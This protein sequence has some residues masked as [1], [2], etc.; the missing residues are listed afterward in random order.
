MMS[1]TWI[2]VTVFWL[3]LGGTTGPMAAQQPQG[4]DRPLPNFDIRDRELPAPSSAADRQVTDRGQRR[5]RGNPHTG[6]LRIVDV[7]DLAIARELPPEGIRIA[8][9]RVAARL[10][11]DGPDL[12]SLTPLRDFTSA[13]N[14]VR[15]VVFGQTVDGIRVLDAEIQV[16]LDGAG[17]AVRITS[18]AARGRNRRNASVISA[19]QAAVAAA[20]NVRP[21]VVFSPVPVGPQSQTARFARGPFKSDVVVTPAWFPMSDALRLAWLVDIELDGDPQRY[22]IVVDAASGEVLLRRNK[23]LYASGQGRVLQSAAM[24]LLDARRPEQHPAGVADCPPATNYELRDLA[25]PFRDPATVL[26]ST[27][28]LSGNNTHVYRKTAASEAEPGVFDGTQWTFDF[29]L[30]SSGGAETSLF[31]ALNF[32]HDFF[33]DL[34][35]D[36]AAGNFQVDNFGRGGLGGD[37]IV[38]LARAVGRNNATFQPAPDGASPTISMFLWDGVG[39][40]GR[41]LDGDGSIDLDGDQDLDIVLHEYHHGVSNRLNTAFSGNEADAIGE[42]GSDFFAYSVNGDTVLAEYSYPGGLRSVNSKTYGDWSCLL[43]ILCDPHSNGEIWANVLWDVRERFRGDNVRGST[44]AAINEVHQLYVD[45][46]ALSPPAPTMLDMRDAILL[47]DTLRNPSGSDSANFCRIWESFAARGMGLD[48]TDTADNGQNRVQAAFTVPN[49]CQP[50]PPPPSVSVTT[51]NATANEAGTVSG[52]FRITR[53]DVGSRALTVGFLLGG[54]A[55]NG[56]DYMSTP[57]TAVIPAGSLFADLVITPIDD[58]LVEPSES[59]SLTLRTSTAYTIASPSAASLSIVSDD[60]A[61]DLIVSLLTAPQIAG[62]GDAVTL[63]ETT[64]NQGTGS[65]APSVTSFYL[66]RDYL[67]DGADLPLGTRTIPGLGVGAADSGTTT[68]TLPTGLVSG[69]YAIFAKADNQSEISEILESNNTRVTSIRIGPDLVVS[70]MSAP[71][72]AGAGATIAITETTLNQGG[73]SA[74]TSATRFYLSAN[75]SLDANDTPLGSRAVPT[76]AASGSSSAT[77]TVSIPSGTPTGQYYLIAN[78][79]DGNAVA[80][81]VETNNVKYVI[82]RVGPDLV[83]S[84]IVAPAR[85]GSGGTIAITDTTA[86]A[87]SGNADA[88]T[89]TFYFSSNYALDASDIR[90]TPSRAVPALAPGVSST[91]STTVSVPDLQ[92]GLWYLIA[93]AD[94]GAQ[95]GETYETNNA[96]YVTILVG[97]DLT[98]ASIVAPSSATAGSTISVTDGVRNQGAGDAGPSVTRFYLSNNVLF[99]S[100]DVLL[101]GTRSVPVVAA[102][103]TNTGTASV[104]LPTGLSGVYFIIVVTDGTNTVAE[105]SET[106]N[107]AFRGITIK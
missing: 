51:L 36:E 17:R 47:A 2:A 41:D 97:P 7:T 91:T 78:A 3:T 34:G 30:E 14:N 60:I 98:V 28:R 25:S 88:S 9:T 40:W 24:T 70:T 13:S 87:G 80:E 27:G 42:G 55:T 53:N 90:L 4:S 23:I 72:T 73:G 21:S 68:V 101:P 106:N 45:A 102:G 67:L 107:S 57:L 59:V 16:H 75:F 19:A 71:A 103:A 5:S 37:P 65:A 86:N 35:F 76:L 93:N 38:G 50:P 92:P 33:Y 18:S 29:P 31:F 48:A 20:A 74:G 43:S 95:V 56:T 104:T 105:A 49:G 15:H 58:T 61:P 85:A 100:G 62:S 11:L 39:C 10:G 6:A 64:K 26:G 96:R 12:E 77:T 1:R 63:S 89:T 94:D 81:P 8:L 82:I 66:S 79:D 69:T 22:D 46:L 32:A 84:S 54:T 52:S 83:V 44:A 99:D